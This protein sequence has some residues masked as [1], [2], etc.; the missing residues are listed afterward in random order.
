MR[1][2]RRPR[3]GIAADDE[4]PTLRFPQPCDCLWT[5]EDELVEA[6]HEHDPRE[7]EVDRQRRRVELAWDRIAA[8]IGPRQVGGRYWNGYWRRGYLVESIAITFTDGDLA[9]PRWSITV[10]WDSGDRTT[11]CTRW[12]PDLGDSTSPPP[13]RPGP[14]PQPPELRT[15]VPRRTSRSVFTRLTRRF[16]LR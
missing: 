5:P 6:P 12:N 8:E 13:R 1:G 14:A 7:A 2:L 15:R 10:L 3:R 9:C 11:H 4:D 16:L